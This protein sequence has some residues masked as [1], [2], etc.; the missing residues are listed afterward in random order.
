MKP[1]KLEV[2]KPGK[3]S[4]FCIKAD[5]ALEMTQVKFS[6]CWWHP[7]TI[8]MKYIVKHLFPWV[9]DTIL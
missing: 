6:S 9:A 5:F 2:W 3:M 4:G 1:F 7:Y 8:R